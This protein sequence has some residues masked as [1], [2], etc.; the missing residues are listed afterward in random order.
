MV[1]SRYIQLLRHVNLKRNFFFSYSYDLSRSLQANLRTPGQVPPSPGAAATHKLLNPRV[2]PYPRTRAPAG[3]VAHGTG[4]PRI[5]FV[6]CQTM[7]VWNT[8]LMQEFMRQ[9]GGGDAA[10]PEHAHW[11]LPIIHGF[12]KQKTLHLQ[13]VGALTAVR[14]CRSCASH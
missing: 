2:A 7:F 12:F 5:G 1:A 13:Q 11:V 6:E 10:V 4:D 3:C 9:V 8:Y 14:W